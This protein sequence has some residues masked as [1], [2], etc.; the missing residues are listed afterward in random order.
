MDD[1]A[2]AGSFDV[3]A[4]KL[5]LYDEEAYPLPPAPTFSNTCSN[6]HASAS[7]STHASLQ[8]GA[9]GRG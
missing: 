7:T 1:S 9:S 6:G 5:P 2:A 3:A 4:Q 8:R